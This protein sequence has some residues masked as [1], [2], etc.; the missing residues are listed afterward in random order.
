MNPILGA[1]T[2]LLIAAVGAVAVAFP[3]RQSWSVWVIVACAT[4]LPAIAAVSAVRKG[5]HIGGREGVAWQIMA[6]SMTLMLPVY[7]AEFVGAFDLEY[8]LIA[9][10]YALGGVAIL[11]VPLP[12][13]GPYQRLVASLDA[14]GFGIVVATGAFWVVS[15][16]DLDFAGSA[17]W[18]V[19]DAAIIAMVGYVTVRRGQQRGT[20]WP[21]VSLILG[22]AAYLA[23]VLISTIGD[24]AYFIGHPADF[25]Y[26]VGMMSFAFAAVAP[27]QRTQIAQH[28][29]KPVRWRRVLA[30]YFLVAALVA[31]LLTHQASQW[32]NDP[33]GTVLELGILTMMLL[34]LVR[35]LAMIAEQR[36][37][38]ELEQNGVIATVSHEL[39]TPLTTVMGFLDLLEEWGDFSDEEKVEMV[40]MMRNQSHVMERVVGDLIS[41]AREEIDQLPI[42]KANVPVADFVQSA[43]ELVPELEQT[44]VRVD[45]AKDTALTADRDRMLQI[46][47]NLL[48]NATKYG[49][50]QVDI[51]IFEDAGDTVIEVHDDGPGV[52]DI[53][54]LVIWERF[55]R[56]PQRQGTIPGSGIG[57]SVARG[58]ARS[59]GGE[60]N[61]RRSEQLDGAC[62]SVR[63]PL[64][65]PVLSQP[66]AIPAFPA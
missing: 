12:N 10:A 16:L 56:G 28:I 15:S 50:G 18:V 60:T 63:I 30:P 29:L 1:R 8:V 49:S 22:V 38:I 5:R 43:I 51:A 42:S 39:R 14:F 53:F 61:Y 27:A 9:L 35:Q 4:A 34:V 20:D 65:R 59:H 66:G 57:L 52:P 40:T 24:T 48:S 58:I 3:G 6:L 17:V 64:D 26:M 41:V 44:T 55:E 21:M 47:T 32:G 54:H 25:A 37:K 31:A 36:R 13:A 7:A 45:I 62:F 23:G 11:T 33:T 2:V 46:V 19:S